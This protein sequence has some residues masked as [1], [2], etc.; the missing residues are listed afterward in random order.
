MLDYKGPLSNTIAPNILAEANKRSEAH[1][2]WLEEKA[3]FFKISGYIH[4]T[5]EGA[6]RAI[7]YSSVNRVWAA[8]RQFSRESIEKLRICGLLG[9]GQY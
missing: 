4:E 7:Q 8:V 1:R 3:K 5:R 2:R 6:S 9:I